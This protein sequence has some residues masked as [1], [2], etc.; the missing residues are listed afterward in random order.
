MNGLSTIGCLPL[1]QNP[2]SLKNSSHNSKLS[3]KGEDD[4]FE[5][6]EVAKEKQE[7]VK[8]L[9]PRANKRFD[10][11]VAGSN[12]LN[13]VISPITSIFE[14]PTSMAVTA[15]VGALGYAL[16]RATKGAIGPLFVVAGG[17]IAAFQAGQGIAQ[18]VKAKDGDE[19]EKSFTTMGSAVGTGAL[20]ALSA[21]PLLKGANIVENVDSMSMTKATVE[22]FKAAKTSASKTL[23]SL[24]NEETINSI[25]QQL[26]VNP[27][28]RLLLQILHRLPHQHNKH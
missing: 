19:R 5:Q 26:Q 14:S 22:C 27:Q 13:G 23:T 25:Y 28:L 4:D 16:L 24:N 7:S 1:R 3:F 2:V 15:G 12:F 10:L 20:T 11:K 8:A 9:D 21:K 6:T 17:A 18:F